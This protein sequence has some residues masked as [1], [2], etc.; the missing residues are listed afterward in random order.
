MGEISSSKGSKRNTPMV[1]VNENQFSM[2]NNNLAVFGSYMKHGNEV[3]TELVDI[4]HIHAT[5]TQDVV[6]NIKRH[7]DYYGEHAHSQCRITSYQYLESD[8][9]SLLVDM[10]ISDENLL[11]QCYVKT[12]LGS[13][14]YLDY[15]PNEYGQSCLI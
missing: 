6:A 1:D 11:D 3:A 4:A 13:S 8:I 12:Q 15:L 9:W 5:A 14:N 2:L 7:I 10:Y